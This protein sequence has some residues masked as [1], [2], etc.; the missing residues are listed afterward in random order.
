MAEVLNSPVGVSALIDGVSSPDAV[1]HRAVHPFPGKIA[2]SSYHFLPRA[3]S[4]TLVIFFSGTGKRNGKFDFW[5]V[6][7]SL[8]DNVLFVSDGRNLWYQEGVGGL[9]NTIEKA[10]VNIRR[11][12][13]A[14]GV[15]QIVTV[16][17]SMGGYGAVL[18]G[19][20]LKAKVLALSFD[21]ILRLPTSPSAKHMPADA[22]ALHPDLVPIVE[23]SGA[24]V[25]IY[26]GEMYTM[27]IVGALRMAGLP[28]VT[29][30]TLRGV[31]HSSA[32]FLENKIGLKVLIGLYARNLPLPRFVEGGTLCTKPHVVA[33]LHRAH[34]LD[35]KKQHAAC[36]DTCKLA[37]MV[38]P[39]SEA[40]HYL[41]GTSYFSLGRFNLAL[42]HLGFV[43]TALPYFEDAQFLYANTLRATGQNELARQS[44]RQQMEK[45][46]KS[47]RVAYNLALCQEALGEFSDAAASMGRAVEL[48][49]R[50]AAKQKLFLARAKRR[51]TGKSPGKAVAAL[52]NYLSKVRKIFFKAPPPKEIPEKPVKKEPAYHPFTASEMQ[53]FDH[54]A[55]KASQH[56]RDRPI[57]NLVGCIDGAN[58][59]L[60]VGQ[61]FMGGS[62]NSSR[63][64]FVPDRLLRDR[65]Y[66]AKMLGESERGQSSE[67][68]FEPY[69][70]PVLNPLKDTLVY[71]DAIYSDEQVATGEHH[72]R[73]KG[74]TP[75]AGACIFFENLW[76]IS[77]RVRGDLSRGFDVAINV[78]KT[79]ASLI[80]ISSSP[81][82]DRTFD[83][84]SKVFA[85]VSRE[86]PGLPAQHTVTFE[87]HGQNGENIGDS[88][89][90]YMEIHRAYRSNVHSHA[91]AGIDNEPRAP[92]IGT[93]VSGAYGSPKRRVAQ[94]QLAMALEDDDFFIATPDYPFPHLGKATA[95]HARAGD[96][97]PTANGTLMAANYMAWARFYVQVLR[98][99]WFPTHIFDA[100][101]RGPEILVSF[102][103]MQPPLRISE[104]C[105]STTMTM[106]HALGFDVEDDGID[107][108]I[109]GVPELVGALTFRIICD[110]PLKNP[111][112]G[113][114]KGSFG[115]V[116]IG[117]VGSGATNIKDSQ[118]LATLFRPTYELG[119]T[120]LL[121]GGTLDN[122]GYEDIDELLGRQ[123]M[124]N[125]AV[126]QRK[127]CK[128]F[129][130]KP[131]KPAKK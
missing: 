36:I 52:Y 27:D 110:R 46:P 94:A 39:R 11:W 92:W 1:E 84:L 66:K 15:K 13:R 96:R 8:E 2:G 67:S 81:A 58:I 20:L 40:L 107:I 119:H 122:E 21:S 126:A 31:D 111:V 23:N 85:A 118:T 48:E 113:L 104:V 93:Q 42:H 37:L 73:A 74:S 4:E 41:V 19:S 95:P 38:D 82:I 34:L 78:S 76:R 43:V 9:G 62:A 131:K 7:N 16:G 112:V 33:L 101:F 49:G 83:A 26:A 47:S 108:P 69:G 103:A 29:I 56:I 65:T 116:D 55:R 105:V 114:A 127:R 5:K 24:R 90:S 68:I 120:N 109:V 14:L 130:I 51:K 64:N 72:P 28:S 61:S 32:R 12:C 63:L 102:R 3:G 60:G 75:L 71:R 115:L 100:R 91:K 57:G 128:P 53:A 6:G 125:W 89:N 117:Q 50:L 88:M 22:R 79:E 77:Q 80:Q 35:H 106:I 54:R 45:W 18:Y 70:A 17:A 129:S 25:H 123:D 99:N 121:A 59:A 30:T 124:S 98:R 87:R 97:H 86:M 44:L 10:V